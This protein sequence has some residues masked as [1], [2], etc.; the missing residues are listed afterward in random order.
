MKSVEWQEGGLWLKTKAPEISEAT[1]LKLVGSR[2]EGDIVTL[3]LELTGEKVV[4]EARWRDGAVVHEEG[5]VT[6]RFV[7]GGLVRVETFE[8]EVTVPGNLTTSIWLE[9][10]VSGHYTSGQ[11]RE[12]RRSRILTS[13]PGHGWSCAERSSQAPPSL[14]DLTV[15]TKAY[16]FNIDMIPYRGGTRNPEEKN[17]PR[18]TLNFNFNFN[19]ICIMVDAQNAKV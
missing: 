5:E 19:L 8:V 2:V 9:V 17:Y 15:D 6:M 7:R 12:G 1:S 4:V 11:V 14:G 16:T 18:A 3:D 10:V 13:M